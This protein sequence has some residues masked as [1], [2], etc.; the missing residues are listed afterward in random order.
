MQD[1]VILHDWNPSEETLRTWAYNEHVELADQDADLV[2][3]REDY[4]PMLL[5]FADDPGCPKSAEILS[6]LDFYLMFL[7]L[8]GVDS[9]LKIVE[10]AVQL[11]GQ[12]KT[13]QV[14]EWRELQAR[15]LRYREGIGPV[16]RELALAIAQDLLNGI[17]RAADLAFVDD[18]PRTWEIQLSVAPSHRHKERLSID[19]ASG[20]FRF[21]R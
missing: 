1:Y 19:K 13:P 12:V 20:Q 5:G 17:S 8:R 9:H 7:V 16:G 15:R 3:H 18:N 21:S 2:L 14:I 10:K 11:T 4:L 6:T